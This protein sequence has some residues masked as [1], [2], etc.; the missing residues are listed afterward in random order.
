MGAYELLRLFEYLDER[1]QE[2][3]RVAETE[4]K[5][6]YEDV[7]QYLKELISR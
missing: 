6:A 5:T 7:R 1:T 4:A 2:C 3:E